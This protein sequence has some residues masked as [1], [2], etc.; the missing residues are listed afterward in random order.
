VNNLHPTKADS[1][2]YF[3][4][5]DQ[6]NGVNQQP[7]FNRVATTQGSFHSSVQSTTQ[8]LQPSRIQSKSSILHSLFPMEE[9]WCYILYYSSLQSILAFRLVARIFESLASKIMIPHEYRPL[10]EKAVLVVRVENDQSKGAQQLLKKQQQWDEA[11]LN[12]AVRAKLK[13]NFRTNIS[14]SE[15]INFVKDISNL[16]GDFLHQIKIILEIKDYPEMKLLR[17]LLQSQHYLQFFKQIEEL[18]FCH[19]YQACSDNISNALFASIRE[20]LHCFPKLTKLCYPDTVHAI[21][22]PDLLNKLT[23][24]SISSPNI[25]MSS[26]ELINL[27]SLY[28]RGI[29]F[30]TKDPIDL[31]QLDNLTNLGIGRISSKVSSPDHSYAP[32]VLNLKAPNLTYFQIQ[33][34]WS[35][36][37]LPNELPK[38]ETFEIGGI[39]GVIHLPNLPNLKTLRMNIE[40]DCSVQLPNKLPNL[41]KLEMR[42][43]ENA[44]LKLPNSLNNL[45]ELRLGFIHSTANFKFPVELPN[46]RS[47]TFLSFDNII[48]RRLPKS[49]PRV[50]KLIIDE[51][52]REKDNPF[53]LSTSLNRLDKVHLSTSFNR[54]EYLK[55]PTSRL[56]EFNL[57]GSMNKLTTLAFEDI[58]TFNLTGSMNNLAM[59]TF[60]KIGTF[61]LAG[62]MNNLSMLTFADIGTFNLT[63]SMNN[64]AMLTFENIGTFNLTGSL[65]NLLM[66]TINNIR[67]YYRKNKTSNLTGSLPNLLKLD[68]GNISDNFPKNTT[69]NLSGSMNNLTNLTFE[70][71]GN[72]VIIQLPKVLNKLSSLSIN[73]LRDPA[74]LKLPDALPN[75][76][77]LTIKQEVIKSTSTNGHKEFH[78][79]KNAD[80]DIKALTDIINKLINLPPLEESKQQIESEKCCCQ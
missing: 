20:N 51:F 13:T 46:L 52:S 44:T 43:L 31:G 16:S 33:E 45:R 29:C 73:N 19:I 34:N 79:Q 70:N 4:Q 78:P 30:N 39:L 5:S 27:K 23:S 48:S 56:E 80:S 55:M 24:L 66:L 76:T 9:I 40:E 42:M 75:L 22:S 3:K 38:L 49:L 74:Y 57:T 58:D 63:G 64:L 59:L 28:I 71:L 61:N 10:S 72:N 15:I 35:N 7:H 25:L 37:K 21:N 26:R 60:K 32:T 54:L 47:L 62:S 11:Q 1:D 6:P 14:V 65:P 67:G 8:F 50:K 12:F 41:V 69:L 18:K 36:V 53:H 68:I 17:E 77:E 2:V